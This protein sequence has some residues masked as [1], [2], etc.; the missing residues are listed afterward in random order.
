MFHSQM[1]TK[2]LQDKMNAILQCYYQ[3]QTPPRVQVRGSPTMATKYCVV[4]LLV[5]LLINRLIYLMILLKRH[6]TNHLD[7]M[8]LGNHR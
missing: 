2:L 6:S 7:H 8:C 3:S 5:V 1:N 4:M